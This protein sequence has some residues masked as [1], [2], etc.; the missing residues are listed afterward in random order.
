MAENKPNTH[1]KHASNL[2]ATTPTRGSSIQGEQQNAKGG[3]AGANQ[4]GASRGGSR[5]EP[6]HQQRAA[7]Q[8]RPQK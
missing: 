4:G 2:D 3:P 1:G 7:K 5:V 6:S 8:D